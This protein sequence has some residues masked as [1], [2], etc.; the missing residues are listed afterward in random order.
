MGE[1]KRPAE[2]LEDKTGDELADACSIEHAKGGMARQ[3][4]EI[5]QR[6]G[7]LS[8]VLTT[9]Q[10]RLAA[11]HHFSLKVR[12]ARAP[13]DCSQRKSIL[14]RT[15]IGPSLV[16]M[17]TRLGLLL[18]LCAMLVPGKAW[19]A[20]MVV[21]E[22]LPSATAIHSHHADHVHAV[23]P[24][25]SIEKAALGDAPA[26]QRDPD[27]GLTHSHGS[28]AGHGFALLSADHAEFA[29]LPSAKELHFPPPASLPAVSRP[30]SLLRPPRAA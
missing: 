14:L 11:S 21:H 22:P 18:L 19:D 28:M 8:T 27:T 23:D 29:G 10:S 4:D 26:E 2:R 16:R 13:D 17:F 7:M 30:N 3:A 6:S 20:H 12:N 9:F 15:S 25:A 1:R 5:G 24:P